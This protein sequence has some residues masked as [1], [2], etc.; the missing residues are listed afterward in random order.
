MS[1]WLSI[2]ALNG[3]HV[4]KKGGGNKRLEGVNNPLIM[5]KTLHLDVLDL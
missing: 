4:M 1:P 3:C 5:P 2:R